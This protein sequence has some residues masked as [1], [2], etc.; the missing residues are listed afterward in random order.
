MDLM[1]F[2]FRIIYNKPNILIADSAETIANGFE[3]AFVEVGGEFR[4]IKNAGWILVHG[5]IFTL[6]FLGRSN[7]FLALFIKILIENT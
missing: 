1:L 4:R 7:L 6:A 3:M 5:Y 2:I